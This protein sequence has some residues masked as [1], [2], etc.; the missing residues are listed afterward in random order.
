MVG[1]GR[2]MAPKQNSL[3]QGRF[4]DMRESYVWV[5]TLGSSY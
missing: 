2:A 5:L 3:L 4:L 1:S